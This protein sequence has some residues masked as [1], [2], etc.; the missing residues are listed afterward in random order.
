MNTKKDFEATARIIADS[1]NAE[2]KR[3]CASY[4]PADSHAA[5]VARGAEGMGAF[6]LYRSMAAAFADHYAQDN[7]RFNRARFFEACG[8]VEDSIKW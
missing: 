4:E 1:Y 6:A 8:I 3:I 2:I 7:P 5:Q